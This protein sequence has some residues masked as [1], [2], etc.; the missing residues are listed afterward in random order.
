MVNNTRI[1]N[2]I[3]Y[4]TQVGM[5]AAIG[6]DD[7]NISLYLCKLAQAFSDRLESISCWNN[8]TKKRHTK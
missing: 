2:F 5:G 7:F 6:Y 1:S 8:N 3:N 4:F